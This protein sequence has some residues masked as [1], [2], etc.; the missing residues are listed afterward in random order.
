MVIHTQRMTSTIWCL[1][2]L[3]LELAFSLIETYEVT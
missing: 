3:E 1:L 2:G